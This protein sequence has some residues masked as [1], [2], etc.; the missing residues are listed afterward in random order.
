MRV[1]RGGFFKEVGGHVCVA[2]KHIQASLRYVR[3]LP[4][5]DVAPLGFAQRRFDLR[6]PT[7]LSFLCL[8]VL[9]VP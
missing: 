1:R 6:S 4:D 3:H 9:A 7:V 5:D 2:L 8:V